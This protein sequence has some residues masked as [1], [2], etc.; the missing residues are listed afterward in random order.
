MARHMS[1]KTAISILERQEQEL[2]YLLSFAPFPE[3][4]QKRMK[5][6]R[7]Q[8]IRFQDE[9]RKYEERLSGVV[10]AKD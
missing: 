5:D 1:L 3:K 4:L 10:R 8:K 9:I 2:H 7:D 6:H